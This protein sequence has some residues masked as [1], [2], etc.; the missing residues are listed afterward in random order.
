MA[1]ILVVDDSLFMRKM[2]IQI[3]NEAGYTV[4]G[5]ATDGNEALQQY[6]KLEPDLVLMDITMPYVTGLEGLE[7][8]KKVD[9]NARVIMCSAMGQ[10]SKILKAMSLGASDF[11]V[12]PFNKYKVIDTIS[13]ALKNK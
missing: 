9:P 6:V 13:N 11:I 1:N 12:K 4:V 10:Q 5:E 3:V 8:I 7:L 2:I